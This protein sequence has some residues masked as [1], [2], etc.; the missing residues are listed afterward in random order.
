MPSLDSW[1]KL[2]K[3]NEKILL[4]KR[5]VLLFQSTC[6]GVTR[7]GEELWLAVRT[8]TGDHYQWPRNVP[9]PEIN[10]GI[11][12]LREKFQLKTDAE[13]RSFITKHTTYFPDFPEIEELDEEEEQ[14]KMEQYFIETPQGMVLRCWNGSMPSLP[15]GSTAVVR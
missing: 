15:G 14:L 9:L 4:E 13:V 2:T 3:A 6:Y 11:D 7:I 5:D 12:W 10:W 1:I 8:H